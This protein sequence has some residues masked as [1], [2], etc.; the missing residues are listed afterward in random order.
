MENKTNNTIWI[1]VLIIVLVLVLFVAPIGNNRW[2]GFCG[3][4]GVY[5]GSMMNYGF[6]MMGG[7]GWLYMA[8][9]FITLILFIIWIV[10]QL[11]K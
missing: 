6:G 1:L 3:M 2:G 11:S 4:M 8:I 10:K 7:L 5:S 9:L